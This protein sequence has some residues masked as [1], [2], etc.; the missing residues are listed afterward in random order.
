[1]A[2]IP[3]LVRDALLAAEDPTFFSRPGV[4]LHAE[5]VEVALREATGSAFTKPSHG[6][7]LQVTRCLSSS[8]RESRAW[9]TSDWHIANF[10]VLGRVERDLPKEAIFETFA[11]EAYFGAHIFGVAMAAQAYF[12]KSLPELTLDE[13]A[14]LAS[15]VKRPMNRRDRPDDGILRRRNA[16]L[17][18]MV[19]A[20]FIGAAAAESA[21]KK[22]LAWTEAAP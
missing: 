11:N 10:I 17:E 22:P 3:P 2:D 15:L 21:E 6:V 1:M 16:V 13:A 8:V 4:N 20:G 5:V 19:A 7:S 18:T 14:L 12:R 9:R